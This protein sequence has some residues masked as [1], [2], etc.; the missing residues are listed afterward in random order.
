M[1]AAQFWHAQEV[2]DIAKEYIEKYHQ[3]IL[4]FKVKVVYRFTDKI[5][6]TGN[7]ER[8]GNCRKI[9][10]LNAHLSNAENDGEPYFAIT[11]PI[12][13]WNVLPQDKRE[14]LVDHQLCHIDAKADQ[15]EDSDGSE[16]VV[17]LS[18][19]PHDLEE[20]TC[21]ARRHGMWQEDMEDFFEAAIKSK[22][23][24]SKSM[25]NSP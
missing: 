21:V 18:M 20:F 7:K 2:E 15:E 17:K 19:K 3:H 13:I 14:A 6:K 12:D 5:S 24:Q 11:I 10:G 1:A 4:D 25:I 23:N 9:T 8:W 16:P 22:E